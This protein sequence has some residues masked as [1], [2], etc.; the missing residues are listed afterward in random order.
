MIYKGYTAKVTYDEHAEIFHGEVIGTQDVITFQSDNAHT[1]GQEFK[2]SI[3]EYL[4]FCK[5]VGKAPDKPF[6]GKFVLRLT[7]ELHRKLYIQAAEHQKSLN[8]LIA[9]K[10]VHTN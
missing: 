3:D 6:S 4:S 5:E 1:L 8:E 2:K 7:P 10:L 9:E